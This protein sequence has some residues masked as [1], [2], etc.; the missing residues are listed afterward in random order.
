VTTPLTYN[1]STGL[2]TTTNI[3]TTSAE[4]ALGFNAGLTTQG[5][6]AIAIGNVAGQTSQGTEAVAI[7]RLAGN[8]GQGTY[9]VAIGV[10][11][12]QTSQGSR[13]V[14]IGSDAGNSLQGNSAVAVGFLAGNSGQGTNAVAIG[15]NAGLL[16][17]HAN[18]IILNGTGVALDSDGASRFFVKPIRALA[19]A[20]PV[21]VYN[22]TTGEITYNSSSIKNKKNVIDL[23]TDTSNIYKIRAREYDWKEDDKH[24]IGYIAEELDAIDTNFTWKQNDEPE[25]IE[26]FNLLLYTIEEMKKLK[27]RV[28]E[29]EKV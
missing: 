16:N 22:S 23:Q 17:Q 5:S 24:F 11:A 6:S 13:C 26:W 10:I 29:L 25:G 21:L 2:L 18:S 3:R 4:I 19:S 1:P 27:A 7:G 12:G 14:A 8:S 9:S 15:Y 28:D 20:S